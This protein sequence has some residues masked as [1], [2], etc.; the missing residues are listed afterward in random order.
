[1][2]SRTV[3]FLCSALLTL[4]LLIDL[5]CIVEARESTFF[6]KF[7]ANE[8]SGVNG[9]QGSYGTDGVRDVSNGYSSQS[10]D[11][12]GY[13]SG[14]GTT[15][16]ESDKAYFA[17]S[18]GAYDSQN[19]GK[20]VAGAGH[21]EDSTNTVPSFENAEAQQ[22][23]GA[24]FSNGYGSHSTPY[25]SE[26]SRDELGTVYG[27]GTSRYEQ[28]NEFASG[29]GHKEDSTNS[30]PSFENTEAVQ[31]EG[32][33]FGKGYGS[34]STPY[35]SAGSRDQ[36]G[37][38]YGSSTSRY[39]QNNEFA[40]GNGQKEDSTNSVPSFENAEAQQNE[41]AYFGKGYGSQ[42]T[43]YRSAG[44][45]DELGTVYGSTTSRYEQNDQFASGR[46][47][48]SGSN[49]GYDSSYNADSGYDRNFDRNSY[50][51]GGTRGYDRNA[52]GS[53]SGNGGRYEQTESGYGENVS[54]GN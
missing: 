7:P 12:A 46:G 38:V 40:S 42:S 53:Y 23:E 5:H 14:S 54:G 25:R 17:G 44:S 37:T 27:S 49:S 32:A 36:L 21:K 11:R 47:V 26:G 6:S 30:V 28:N 35:R 18:Y 1:M 33:D 8:R 29:N 24:D 52:Y 9:Y 39:E 19:V 45:R 34:Q 15:Y 31:N 20:E 48:R 10:G 43:P 13:G 4:S 50:N 51:P 22:N 16:E 2:A 41:G 3:S